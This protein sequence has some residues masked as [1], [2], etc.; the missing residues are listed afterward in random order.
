MEVH[1]SSKCS[2]GSYIKEC[3]SSSLPQT[4]TLGFC[5]ESSASF[6]NS[7]PCLD[8]EIRIGMALF[9]RRL[10]RAAPL[11]FG[12]AFRQHPKSNFRNRFPLG[13]IAAIS[14][15]ITYCYYLSSPEMVIPSTISHLGLQV[16]IGLWS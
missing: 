14:G 2:D 3:S 4:K 13:A 10:A 7:P 6:S 9:F 15:G 12:N 11:A 8:L 5:L 16:E 1:V